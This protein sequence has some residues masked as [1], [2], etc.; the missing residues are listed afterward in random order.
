M[1]PRTRRE[2]LAENEALYAELADIAERLDQLLEGEA[3]GEP[4]EN[5]PEDDE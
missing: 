5:P 1:D 4:A 3:G 2:L